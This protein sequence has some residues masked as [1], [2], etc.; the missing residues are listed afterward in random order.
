MEL[1]DL[2][3]IPW[4][5]TQLVYHS[6][7][8]LGREALVL[9]SPATPYVS[10]GYHQDLDQEVDV[11]RCAQMGLPLFRREV[12]GGAVYLD[13]GQLFYH[14]VIRKD[15]PLA[16]G[17]TSDV[18]ARV[19]R[20]PVAALG[21]LGIVAVH[22][23][24]NDIVVT[25]SRRKI[26]GN[27]A[28]DIGEM[29]VIVG[30]LISTFDFDAMVAV[31]RVPSEKFRDKV[32]KTMRDNLTTLETELGSEPPRERV[33]AALRRR[34]EEVLGP[35]D[36]ASGIDAE[37]RAEMDRLWRRYSADDWLRKRGRRSAARRLK[38]R[39]GVELVSGAW[40]APGGLV[41]ADA[42]VRDGRL[43]GVE[44]TGDFFIFPHE[45]LEELEAALGGVEMERAA[46]ER[47]AATVLERPDV[48]ALGVGPKD[49]ANALLGPPPQA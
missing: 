12:G 18:F 29:T 26:S 43:E 6:L 16:A 34:F 33:H 24:V 40:K 17:T 15:G 42:T 37:L 21:D 36:V 35:L 10:I 30:S 1:L 23:P 48:E 11:D 44:L 49:V 2:G 46:V 41:R 39:E 19:L 32:H 38:V 3:L 28:A 20:A 7:C 13:S 45:A 31:L 14:V 27:G 25:S 22:R 4:Q 9:V 8:H 47:A 5:E